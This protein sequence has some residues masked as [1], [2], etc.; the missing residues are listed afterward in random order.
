MNLQNMKENLPEA[1]RKGM[2]DFYGRNFAVSPEVL[3]PRPET[4]AII[5]EVK[6]L[7]GRAYLPGMKTP[8]RVL[9]EEPVILDIGTGSGCIAITLK[10]ETPEASVIGM[11]ISNE[12]LRVARENALKL[13]A[14]VDF[15]GSDLLVDYTGP[16]PDVVVANLPYVDEDWEWIDKEALAAEPRLALYAKDH[17]LELIK[18]LIEQA[19]KIWDKDNG[20]T[21]KRWL[22]LEADPC[23]HEDIVSY[24]TKCGFTHEK[25]NGF[26][27]VFSMKRR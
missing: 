27:L 1:Y 3:I 13:K 24:A 26:A 23:Q 19:E 16:E 8:K 21:G 12:A 17:G 15:V 4:E 5:D 14:E 22:L 9:P 11:D 20:G 25:T 7:S 18:Q 2:Q 10:L 6:L